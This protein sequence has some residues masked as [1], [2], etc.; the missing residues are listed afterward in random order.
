MYF[1]MAGF[2]AWIRQIIFL[3]I[4]I[5]KTVA[6][7]DSHPYSGGTALELHPFPF[8]TFMN[9]VTIKHLD[10]IVLYSIS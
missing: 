10:L 2:L 1:S 7:N 4:S 5:S 9:K 3:P 8:S 6:I